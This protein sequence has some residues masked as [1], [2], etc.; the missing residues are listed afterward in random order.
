VQQSVESKV[1]R[2]PELSWNAPAFG[3]PSVTELLDDE[4]IAYALARVGRSLESLAATGRNGMPSSGDINMERLI[5]DNLDLVRNVVFQVAVRFPRHV[6]R[7][8][9][10]RAGSLGLVEAARRYDP[11]RGVPFGHFAAQRIRGAILD[12]VRAADW[13]PRSVRNQTRALDE[14]EQRLASQLGRSPSRE[15][16]ASELCMTVEAVARLREKAYRSVVLALE[17]EVNDSHEDDLSLV[18]ILADP[19]GVEPAEELEHREE[20][21]FLRDA[22][23][24]LPEPKRIVV[25]GYFLENRT[26]EELGEL[27]GV[28]QSRISQIRSDAMRDIKEGMIAQFEEGELPRPEEMVGRVAKRK[29]KYA[30]D[31][32]LA[33]DSFSRIDDLG[34]V[35]TSPL[36]GQY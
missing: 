10:H 29:A 16:V 13:A 34:L 33:S 18:D 6:D 30:Y 12:A 5:E 23:R 35:V 22:I 2:L 21:A 3:V 1:G 4:E 19:H 17:H 27:L 9:L 31:I 25:T 26:S 20:L 15:E 8:E 32:S 36:V 11:A 14:A 7:E 28:T 24:L